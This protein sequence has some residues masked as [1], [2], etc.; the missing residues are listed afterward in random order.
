MPLPLMLL[1]DSIRTV[2]AIVQE[3]KDTIGSI[4]SGFGSKN[5]PVKEKLSASLK[6]LERRLGNV[7]QLAEAAETYFQTDESIAR[8]MALC[9]RTAQFV[10]ENLAGAGDWRNSEYE[11]TWSVLE[12]LFQDMDQGR[13]FP[14]KVMLDRA[15][16]YTDRDKTQIEG[17]LNEFTVAFERAQ[18]YVNSKDAT[19]LVGEIEA[20]TRPLKDAD[21][22]LRSTAYDE[23]LAALKG[24]QEQGGGAVDTTPGP[25]R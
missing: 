20:M 13:E 1:L 7:G 23:I 2:K 22:A 25:E 14:R 11:H 5:D 4:R 21:L 12:L 10:N 19:H 3:G 24:L 6:E 18:A 15:E 9:Q 17:K 16:W 8:L